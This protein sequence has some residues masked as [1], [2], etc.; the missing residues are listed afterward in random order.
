ME[1]LS[2]HPRPEKKTPRLFS[3]NKISLLLPVF[4]S[5]SSIYPHLVAALYNP[6]PTAGQRAAPPEQVGRVKYFT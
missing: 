3:V 1:P 4:F 2:H 5:F 6:S